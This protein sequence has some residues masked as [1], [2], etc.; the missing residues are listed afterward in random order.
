MKEMVKLFNMIYLFK[1]L[2]SSNTYETIKDFF[3]SFLMYNTLYPI[4][5]G[6]FM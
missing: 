5:T 2:Q 6:G 4:E 1:T 3:S